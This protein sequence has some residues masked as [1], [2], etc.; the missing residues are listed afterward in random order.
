[1]RCLSPAQGVLV[2]IESVGMVSKSRATAG[3]MANR[4][5]NHLAALIAC[6]CLTACITQREH[7]LAPSAIGIVLNA[8]TGKPVQN[9]QVRFVGLEESASI[10]TG[11][12]GR[13]T[14]D[15]RTDKRTIVALPVG[16]IYRDTT[17]VEASAP[18]LA[19]GYARAAFINGGSPAEALYPVTLLMFPPDVGATPLHDLMADC[20]AGPEQNHAL[21]VSD[22][23]AGIDPASR[24]EWLD[25]D[26]AKAL[27]E[28]LSYA[29]PASA[30]LACAQQTA[31]Y[32]LFSAQKAPLRVLVGNRSAE[33]AP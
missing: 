21:Y 10:T 24:P 20:I 13:F 27:D 29:L 23:L 16:G 2:D 11:S 32:E 6:L 33:G 22:F 1:M 3:H 25:S 9:A 28:H 30:F 26:T 15:G 19:N 4:T 18:E 12:D 17:L 31:A 5:V 14:L 8:G 7:V